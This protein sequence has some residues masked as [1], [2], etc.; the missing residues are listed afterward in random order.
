MSITAKPPG[1]SSRHRRM[2]P[3]NDAIVPPYASRRSPREGPAFDTQLTAPVQVH[4]RRGQPSSTGA[5]C[6]ERP[7]SADGAAWPGP[8]P[9]EEPAHGS[10]R[11]PGGYARLCRRVLP[12]LTGRV[13]PVSGLI[14]WCQLGRGGCCGRC[15]CRVGRAQCPI[16]G[17]IAAA[18]SV[19]SSTAAGSPALRLH[20]RGQARRGRP[21]GTGSFRSGPF[22]PSLRPMGAPRPARCRGRPAGRGSGVD[23][24]SPR[25]R[26]GAAREENQSPEG[27]PLTALAVPSRP[28]TGY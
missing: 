15:A 27:G 20:G 4:H 18:T 9:G 24:P 5:R 21:P 6:A 12:R 1:L 11:W 10:C 19:P 22:G 26:H 23:P 13:R 17:V 8:H 14:V 3:R 2:R 16:G 25:P 28:S 7:S